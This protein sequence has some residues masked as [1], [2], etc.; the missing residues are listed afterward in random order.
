MILGLTH[1]VHLL[2]L[3]QEVEHYRETYAITIQYTYEESI[4]QNSLGQISL[5]TY[6]SAMVTSVTNPHPQQSFF[7]FFITQVSTPA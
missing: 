3:V 6:A 2:M 4:D 5:Q 1:D 7:Y